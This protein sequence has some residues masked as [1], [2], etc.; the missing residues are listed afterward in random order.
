[1]KQNSSKFGVFAQ[2]DRCPDQGSQRW[3]S[4]FKGRFEAATMVQRHFDNLWRP[5][6]LFKGNRVD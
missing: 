4:K 2:P 5:N 6:S 3:I 1:M